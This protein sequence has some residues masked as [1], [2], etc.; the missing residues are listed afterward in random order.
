VSNSDWLTLAAIV[1]LLF[2]SAFFAMA[3]TA[4]VRMNRIRAMSL[5]EEGRRGSKRLACWRSRRTPST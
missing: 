2:T 3:E 1:V 5:E 4:L